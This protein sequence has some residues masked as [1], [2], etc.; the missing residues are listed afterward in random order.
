MTL[1]AGVMQGV[2]SGG[3]WANRTGATLSFRELRLAE[4]QFPKIFVLGF[5]VNR[6]AAP[7]P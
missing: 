4:A 1:V 7:N 5:S 6:D 2:R 3:T